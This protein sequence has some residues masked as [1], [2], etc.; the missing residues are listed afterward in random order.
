MALRRQAT[1]S[2]LRRPVRLT[3][4]EA[5]LLRSR[6]RL[7]RRIHREGRASLISDY[8]KK[9]PDRA[10]SDAAYLERPLRI[11]DRPQPL[12]DFRRSD[13]DVV[14]TGEHVSIAS[15]PGMDSARFAPHLAISSAMTGPLGYVAILYAAIRDRAKKVLF[16]KPHNVAS[17]VQFNGRHR[18]TRRPPDCIERS[19]SS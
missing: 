13:E 8:A 2:R 1:S 3:L 18:P 12:G 14:S 11:A 10:A 15:L 19:A 17:V 9:T 16:Y 6:R 7:N 5:K 4:H